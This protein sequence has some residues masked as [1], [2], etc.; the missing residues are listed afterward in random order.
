MR[1]IMQSERADKTTISGLRVQGSPETNILSFL[2]GNAH[3]S[4]K[5]FLFYGVCN[6]N[7][8]GNLRMCICFLVSTDYFAPLSSIK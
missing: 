7:N 3:R 5:K 8:F 2:A 6:R 4:K 1:W